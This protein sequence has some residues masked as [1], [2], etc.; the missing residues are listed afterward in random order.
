MYNLYALAEG[1]RRALE[2][3]KSEMLLLHSFPKGCCTIAC[4]LLQRFLYENG[5]ETERI[6]GENSRNSKFESHV[7]LETNDGT[8]IDITGDQYSSRDD[9]FSYQIPVYVGPKDKFHQLF[10]VKYREPYKETEPD[11]FESDLT[12]E[13]K[14][15]R[16]YRMIIQSMNMNQ[17]EKDI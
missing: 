6:V 10:R 15:D 14:N 12:V 8:V 13:I 2:K 17:T 11:P 7:W 9:A 4:F 1:F 5:I 3:N 16:L